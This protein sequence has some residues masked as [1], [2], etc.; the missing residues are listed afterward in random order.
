MIYSRY[1]LVVVSVDLFVVVGGSGIPPLGA[2]RTFLFMADIRGCRVIMV[3]FGRVGGLR[4]IIRV[5]G[6]G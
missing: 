2:I 6:G 3:A 5:A 4:V 1:L